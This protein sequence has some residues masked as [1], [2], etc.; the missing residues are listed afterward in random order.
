MNNDKNINNIPFLRVNKPF[1]FKYGLDAAC[2]IAE[3]VYWHDQMRKRKSIDAEGYFFYEQHK[4]ERATGLSKHRQD[5]AFEVLK[6]AR[7]LTVSDLKCGIP[8][9]NQYKVHVDIYNT[10]VLKAFDEY[11]KATEKPK[12]CKNKGTKKIAVN[13]NEKD[14]GLKRPRYRI[15]NLASVETP[16]YLEE[17]SSQEEIDRVREQEFVM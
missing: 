4:I 3:L 14:L 5:K 12:R 13:A 15:H 7:I 2:V 1:V 6:K 17:I 9:K 8:P 11:N 10:A 16:L